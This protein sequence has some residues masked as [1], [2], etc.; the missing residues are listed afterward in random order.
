MDVAIAFLRANV[1]DR[2][3]LL[4]FA[5]GFFSLLLA[6]ASLLRRKPSPATWCFFAGM[7]ALGIDSIFTGLSLRATPLDEVIYWLTRAFI[8]K[9]FVPVI[10]LCFSLTY[11]R[12]DYRE[13]LTR[14]R[15]PLATRRS[16]ADRSVV[17]LPRSTVSGRFRREQPGDVWRLQ[18]GAIAKA[19]NVILLVALVLILMNLEQTFRSAVGTMRWRIKFV[20][21]A[22]ARDLRRPSLRSEPGDSLLRARHRSVERRV[23]CAPDR[24]RLP[25]AGLRANG[26]GRD[27]RVSFAG[28]PSVVADGPHRRRLPLRRRRAGAGGAALWRSRDFP[29]SGVCRAPGHGRPGRAASVRPRP[30]EDSCVRRPPFQKGPARFGADLDVVLA[31]VGQRDRS[32]RPV[33]G[34]REIDLR[35]V[36]RAVGH[37][38]AAGRGE[39]AARRRS[40]DRATSAR[41]RRHRARRTPRQAPS[42]PDCR[43]GR[44]RSIWKT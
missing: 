31:A 1:G 15:V 7:T 14:W 18:F 35:N 21:L 17:R 16:A 26:I 10:W 43:R 5:A 29:V 3:F 38:L 36:R 37:H 44:R 6:V 23:G 11:S 2:L 20:V 40:L 8:V 24:V 22:L 12:S 27:R 34:V 19:L 42:S 28:R 30:A 32:G 25:G 9:S 4:P 13:F 41:G 39:G 33:R